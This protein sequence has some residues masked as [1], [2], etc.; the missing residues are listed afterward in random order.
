VQAAWGQC[1]GPMAAAIALASGD[2]P[3]FNATVANREGLTARQMGNFPAGT[4]APACHSMEFDSKGEGSFLH[5]VDI[6]P[7]VCC[8]VWQ[9]C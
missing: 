6:L 8:D 1:L 2:V 5:C 3:R 4:A 7:A 9:A